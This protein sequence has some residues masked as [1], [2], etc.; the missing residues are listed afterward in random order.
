MKALGKHC[1]ERKSLHK[2]EIET[3]AKFLGKCV[4]GCCTK[5]ASVCKELSTFFECASELSDNDALRICVECVAYVIN[6]ADGDM[7]PAN[8][9]KI[10]RSIWRSRIFWLLSW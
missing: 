7:D 8:V 3:I 10:M 2:N 9:V 5:D 1:S 4:T 6:K